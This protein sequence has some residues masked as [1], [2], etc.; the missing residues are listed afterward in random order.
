MLERMIQDV[1]MPCRG[2]D[3]E[4]ALCHAEE[5]TKQL[6]SRNSLTSFILPASW[7]THTTHVSQSPPHG[8]QAEIYRQKWRAQ[9]G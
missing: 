1:A 8:D 3:D 4:M 2:K 6:Q 5:K 7:F 9:R